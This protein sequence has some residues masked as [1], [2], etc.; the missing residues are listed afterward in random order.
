MPH[1]KRPLRLLLPILLIAAI[2]ICHAQK[3]ITGQVLSKSDQSPIPGA[4]IVVKGSKEGTSSGADGY[5]SIKAKTGDLL[6]ITGVG[7]TREEVVIGSE[8]YLLISV[9]TS[10]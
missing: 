8:N 6:M 7:I 1:L 4:S 5:F 9:T 2:N 10:S 3:L